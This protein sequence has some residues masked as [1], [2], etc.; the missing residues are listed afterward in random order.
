MAKDGSLNLFSGE[1]DCKN[2]V[3][4]YGDE[5]FETNEDKHFF[6]ESKETGKQGFVLFM[7]DFVRIVEDMRRCMKSCRNGW[8]LHL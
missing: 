7:G 5:H 4:E 2:I 1:K 3:L 8:M 6:K